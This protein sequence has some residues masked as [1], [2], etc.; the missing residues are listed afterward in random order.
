MSFFAQCPDIGACPGAFQNG[1]NVQ[2]NRKRGQVSMHRF[3]M[4]TIVHYVGHSKKRHTHVPCE[5][6]CF[7]RPGLVWI[8]ED[9][10]KKR[11]PCPAL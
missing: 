7:T 1:A 4:P 2:S 8:G 9:I 11:Y 5:V 10:T 6:H 3:E